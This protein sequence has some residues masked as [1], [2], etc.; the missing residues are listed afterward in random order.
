[1]GSE[2]LRA[3]Y[4]YI[5]TVKKLVRSP[6]LNNMRMKERNRLKRLEEKKRSNSQNVFRKVTGTQ[7]KNENVLEEINHFPSMKKEGL[8]SLSMSIPFLHSQHLHK[9]DG[10]GHTV[11][12]TITSSS[13]SSSSRT[14]NLNNDINI[15]IN[16]KL[17]INTTSEQKEKEL[18]ES[19][20]LAS[21]AS[22]VSR[23]VPSADGWTVHTGAG[24]AAILDPFPPLFSFPTLA[25]RNTN[26]SYLTMK[27][28]HIPCSGPG[29]PS[30]SHSSGTYV[31]CQIYS[32]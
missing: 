19:V 32:L 30:S 5:N 6:S 7:S 22:A 13:S 15:S 25:P 24:S 26:S 4:V 23:I 31:H 17:N 16:K 18:V 28:T 14:N 12:N 21:I 8:R 27:N 1:M 3:E 10:S 20:A 9:S 11:S 2:S 29:S